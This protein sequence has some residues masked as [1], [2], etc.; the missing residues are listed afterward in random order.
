MWIARELA[1]L[2]MAA[3]EQL[4]YA[5][6]KKKIADMAASKELFVQGAAENGVEKGVAEEIFSRM[7]DFA[8]YGFNKAHSASYAINA[9]QTA[10]LKTHYPAEFMAAQLSSIMSDRD[11][12][13]AYV[14]ECRRLGVEVAP[15]DV[16]ASESLFTVQDGKIRFGL[17]AIKHVSS[18]AA[19]ALLA[20]RLAHGPFRDIYELCSRLEPGK[21]NKTS[22]ENLARANALGS[23]GGT[24]PA[25]W[26]P[27]IRPWSG[28]PASRAT[29]RPGSPRSSAIVGATA[30]CSPSRR[31]CR[32]SR[33]SPPASCS[34]WRR[35]LL[36]V[37]LSGHPLND[38][39][40]ALRQVATA[41]AQEINEGSKLGEVAFGGI[42]IQTRRR[43][44]K[45]NKMMAFV[46]LEDL[47]GVIETVIWSDV[48]ERSS[49]VL[50]E[51]AIVVM[52]GRAE[53]DER[54]REEK[55]GAGQSKVIVDGVVPLSETEAVGRL[56][57]GLATR[58]GSG[59]GN[60]RRASGRRSQEQSRTSG[61]TGEPA[62]APPPQPRPAAAPRTRKSETHVHIKIPG[63]TDLKTLGLL[64][65]LIESVPGPFQHLPARAGGGSRAHR[66]SCRRV[67]GRVRRH[68]SLGVRGI[69]GD[70]AVW[71]V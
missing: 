38:A 60:G 25:R 28:A 6:R 15:P 31:R 10:Y 9:Y 29:A 40:D 34:R 21:L 57:N 13:A 24:P 43:V 52:R 46:T 5:M 48:Y 41:T 53:V 19:E 56:L 2:S 18:V 59:S 30:S 14:N 71:L 4:L 58:S 12:V 61:R 37:Y 63:D 44:T 22:L 16:N 49:S 55:E 23:L 51:G 35:S 68:I 45:S 62:P 7:E 50:T 32:C 70:D 67:P 26:R 69:F 8:G 42:I 36:G 17:T 39:T 64:R 11:K 20:E 54:W 1:D 65:E 27:S 3:A 47:T 33:S 66:P